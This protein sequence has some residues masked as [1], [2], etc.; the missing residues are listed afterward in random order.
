[1][2]ARKSQRY[3]FIIRIP[4]DF[5]LLMTKWHFKIELTNITH[6]Y[7]GYILAKRFRFRFFK[8]AG[9]PGRRLS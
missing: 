7:R 4:A 5:L 1:M 3:A 2:Y 6:F 9:Y 8:N